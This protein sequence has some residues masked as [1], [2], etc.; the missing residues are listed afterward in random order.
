MKKSLFLLLVISIF[1]LALSACVE[2]DVN[3]PLELQLE[4]SP[5]NIKSEADSTPKYPTYPVYPPSPV[6]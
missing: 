4:L 5:D 2:E 6:L 3:P 1:G